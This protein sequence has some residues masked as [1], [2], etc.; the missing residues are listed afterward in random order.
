MEEQEGR[1]K[2]GNMIVLY[3]NK[4]LVTLGPDCTGKRYT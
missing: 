4:C 3:D 1:K 2:Y